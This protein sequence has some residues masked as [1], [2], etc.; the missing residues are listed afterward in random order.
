M[1]VFR[2]LIIAIILSSFI[3]T[4]GTRAAAAPPPFYYRYVTDDGISS[5]DCPRNAPCELRYAIDD[6]AL[7]ED[8]IIVHSGTYH[9]TIPSSELIF[10]DKTLTLKGSCEFDSSHPSICYPEEQN[11]ILDAENAKRVFRIQ[12][13]GVEEVSIEGFT[14]TRGLGTDPAPCFST[15]NG[16]GGG[17]NAYNLEK[18]TLKNNYIWANRAGSTDG[19]GGGLYAQNINHLVVDNNTII[20]NQATDNGPGWGGGAM[21]FGSGGPHAVE[22][23]NN[24]FYDNEI[25]TANTT[26][27]SG[28]SIFIYQSNNI[29]IIGNAFEYNNWIH[30]NVD[31]QGTS[32]FLFQNT[33]FFIEENT[34]TNDWGTS[35]VS[36]LD[37]GTSYNSIARNKW[38]NNSVYRNIELQGQVNV[39]IINNFLGRQLLAPLSRG[40]SST[41]ID[42][43]G[44][45][46]DDRVDAGIYF[47]T[48]GA[49]NFGIDIGSYADVNIFSNIFTDLTDP[50]QYTGSSSSY[51][52]DTNLFHNYDVLGLDPSDYVNSVYA[53]PRLV[54]VANGDFH[55]LPNSGAIDKVFVSDFDRDIDGNPRPIGLG[56]IPYDLGAD[57]FAWRDYMPLISK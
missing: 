3:F 1:K 16:C 31:L 6:V 15:I 49:A 5:G 10:L 4:S 35:V 8:I 21:V 23:T 50:I 42:I 29:Q 28:G 7:P 32:I 46:S 2:F 39:D 11:S 12:G 30:Q 17:I 9:S 45:S 48:F 20:F 22:F 34:F 18:L 41:L 51:I 37:G 43:E 14:I 24:L 27:N 38:W 53:D 40:G 57:E 52:I 55:L 13:T 44:T 33:G 47:N 19:V 54:D 25:S 36:V 56:A 26:S